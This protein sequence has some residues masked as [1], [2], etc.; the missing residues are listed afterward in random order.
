MGL[1]H[2]CLNKATRIVPIFAAFMQSIL[3]GESQIDAHKNAVA[4]AAFVCT[5]TGAWPR[6]NK[7]KI[8]EIRDSL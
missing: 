2:L 5:K 1:V 7:K 4:A 6:Y 3:N 8:K